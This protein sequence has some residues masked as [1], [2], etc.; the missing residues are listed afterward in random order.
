VPGRHA[1]DR[2]LKQAVMDDAGEH[3]REAEGHADVGQAVQEY[4][5]ATRAS[6]AFG[7]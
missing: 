6:A 5:Y 1:V 4:R 7:D 2:N 3:R